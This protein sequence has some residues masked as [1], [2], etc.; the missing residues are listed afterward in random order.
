MPNWQ[1]LV[2]KSE[3][4]SAMFKSQDFQI[5]YIKVYKFLLLEAHKMNRQRFLVFPKEIANP[6]VQ[7]ITHIT[8]SFD[9]P[10]HLSDKCDPMR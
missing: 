1:R 7:F 10:E 4:S 6:N 8:S 3:E 5:I 9:L 2:G